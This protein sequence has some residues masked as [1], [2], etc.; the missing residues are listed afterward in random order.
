MKF[1]FH[2]LSKTAFVQGLGRVSRVVGYTNISRVP[3][4]KIGLWV[5]EN[6]ALW[7]VAFINYMSPL[8]GDIYKSW[9]R[10]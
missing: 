2:K 7:V 10:V 5:P 3:K 6:I 4:L 1:V 9:L 8:A